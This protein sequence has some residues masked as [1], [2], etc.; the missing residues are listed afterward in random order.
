MREISAPVLI[1]DCSSPINLIGIVRNDLLVYVDMFRTGSDSEDIL[2]KKISNA[3][4]SVRQSEE[5][6]FRSI[7][8]GQGPGSFTGLRM[9]SCLVTGLAWSL[10]LPVY[11]VS[12]L[13][14]PQVFG[15][16]VDLSTPYVVSRK[17]GKNSYFIATYSDTCNGEVTLIDETDLHATQ[18]PGLI[19]KSGDLYAFQR[20]GHVCQPRDLY[21]H[22]PAFKTVRESAKL[23]RCVGATGVVAH[24][25]DL[26]AI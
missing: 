15:D 14:I 7:I 17:A 23:R 16:Q 12:S 13:V 11:E 21:L 2:T 22:F 5:G 10:K 25:G 4:Q 20:V 6:N 1:V 19:E 18:V 26:Y 9:C 24:S 3:I 8:C